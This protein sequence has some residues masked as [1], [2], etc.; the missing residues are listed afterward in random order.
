M[1]SGGS[2]SNYI[3]MMGYTGNDGVADETKFNKLTANFALNMKLL[4]QLGV[5][6][7]INLSRVSRDGNRNLRDR[8]AEIEYL[9]DLTTPL[10]PVTSVYRS[11]LDIYEEYKKNDN[12]NNLLNG[13]LGMNYNWRGLYV[14]TR[15]MLDYNTNVRHVFWPMD[16]MESVNYVSN[17]SGYNR[18]LIWGSWYPRNID[19]LFSVYRPP[20]LFRGE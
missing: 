2:F 1:G 12:L 9:P 16:L 14:D 18:R 15:L 11:Y 5:S 20:F 8:Y 7:L 19:S 13:Y 10:S 17:Y 4:E 3:F 6:C